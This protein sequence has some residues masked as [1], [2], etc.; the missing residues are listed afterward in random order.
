MK[1]SEKLLKSLIDDIDQ[2]L[3]DFYDLHKGERYFTEPLYDI[4]VGIWTDM[5][6]GKIDQGEL[7]TLK[8]EC[9]KLIRRKKARWLTS[10]FVDLEQIKPDEYNYPFAYI[11]EMKKNLSKEEWKTLYGEKTA[12]DLVNE[13][14]NEAIEWAKNEDSLIIEYPAIRSITS[15]RLFAAFEDDILRQMFVI[16]EKKYSLKFGEFTKSYIDEMT[17]APY[18]GAGTRKRLYAE[19]FDDEEDPPVYIDGRRVIVEIAMDENEQE[20]LLFSIRPPQRTNEHLN[21]QLVELASTPL[22]LLDQKD[23]ELLMMIIRSAVDAGATNVLA[24]PLSDLAYCLA[25]KSKRSNISNKYYN[26]AEKRIY[27]IA[28]ATYNIYNEKTKKQTGAINFL[29]SALKEYRD[30]RPYMMVTLGPVI[31]DAIINNQIRRI[32]SED[33]ERIPSKIG[34]LII[35]PLQRERVKAYYRSVSTGEPMVT[36]FNYSNFLAMVN[37]GS[38]SKHTNWK[39]IKEILENDFKEQ[40]IFVENLMFDNERNTVVVY[41]I[42]LTETEIHDLRAF[43]FGEDKAL[44][45]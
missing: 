1:Y 35:L 4:A 20:T 8:N 9:F 32:P 5:V 42:P 19:P 28:N 14:T 7:R 13:K 15:K 27:N 30:G 43:G 12:E 34:K 24:V 37:F 16:G 6:K 23:Q 40:G 29:G 36:T 44:I 11:Y 25:G 31:S 17:S 18:F 39:L 33:Y 21:E 22:S 2:K 3:V 41:W 45:Q 26:D 38:R 10:L